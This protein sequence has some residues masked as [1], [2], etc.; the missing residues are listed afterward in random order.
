VFAQTLGGRHALAEGPF[1]DLERFRLAAVERIGELRLLTFMIIWR[2]ENGEKEGESER[3]NC[4]QGTS[5][6]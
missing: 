6:Q 4:P 5:G 2:K 3:F 1:N